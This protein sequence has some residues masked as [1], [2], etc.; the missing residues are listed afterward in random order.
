MRLLL[1]NDDGIDAKGIRALA[2]ELAKKHDV[3][4]VA[5]DTQRSGN[6]HKITLRQELHVHET[7]VHGLDC[8]CYLT[9]GTPADCVRLGMYWLESAP[10]DAVIT[11][12]NQGSNLG[13]DVL[14]SGTVG[15]STEA[16][17]QGLPALAVSL[18]N[19]HAE[20]LVTAAQCAARVISSGIL[21]E[22]PVG[23]SLNLN[24]PSVTPEELRGIKWTCHGVNELRMGWDKDGNT[25]TF[26][27]Q[28][29]VGV[30]VGYIDDFTAVEQG[31]A[32]LSPLDLDLNARDALAKFSAAYRFDMPSND[33]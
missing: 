20:H 30:D 8:P 3:V 11:G 21:S 18:V 26:H 32:S 22:L 14:Y 23:I 29:R 31:W 33:D 6:S 24:V 13:T 5:P 16:A 27:G 17:M 19:W 1:T 28:P 4:I 2:A 7:R 9:D 10:F 12:I 25:I 15:A